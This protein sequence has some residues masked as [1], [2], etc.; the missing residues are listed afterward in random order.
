MRRI[1]LIGLAIVAVLV[2]SFTL[3]LAQE[4]ESDDDGLVPGRG[5]NFVDANGDNV[6]DN[7]SAQT[8]NQFGWRYR[9][10]NGFIDED[11]D[12]VCDNCDGTGPHGPM[13]GRCAGFVD[14]DGDGICDNCPGSGSG[15]HG[16]HFVDADGDGVCDLMGS[17][18]H[19]HGGRG[20]GHRGRGGNSNQP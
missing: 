1:F 16:P 17:G 14:E 12:G 9:Q 7:C 18:P 19:G 8:A 15:P 4:T 10:Q 11:G 20:L 13:N 5:P 3:A 6:C 2:A